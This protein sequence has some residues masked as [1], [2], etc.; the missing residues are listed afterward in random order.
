MAVLN[1]CFLRIKKATA[2]AEPWL[3]AC[4][5]LLSCQNKMPPSAPALLRSRESGRE[6]RRKLTG[7]IVCSLKR[8]MVLRSSHLKTN[9][10]FVKH[11]FCKT[12]NVPPWVDESGA[13]TPKQQ[14]GEEQHRQADW[15]TFYN[16]SFALAGTA[17]LT[18]AASA[19]MISRPR[20]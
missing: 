15:L 2:R 13:G 5:C 1:R 8:N 19:V 3:L 9:G 17:G 18:A 12:A 14:Q 6:R 20:S 10:P 7:I 4:F 11:N 16:D